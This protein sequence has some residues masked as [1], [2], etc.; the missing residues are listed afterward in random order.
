MKI[1]QSNK[2]FGLFVIVFM[3][4]GIQSNAQEKIAVV[5]LSR[6]ENTE[7]VAKLIQEKVGGNLIALEKQ[8]PYPENYQEIVAQVDRENE[9][10][11]LP[12][13]KTKIENLKDYDILFVGFPTWDMQMPPPM[14][15]FLTENDLSG[16][17]VIPFNTN[18]GFGVGQGFDQLR[19]LC[20]DSKILKGF[21]VE[22]G[23]EKKGV[24]LAIKGERKEKVEDQV[25]TWLTSIGLLEKS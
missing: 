24:L 9:E 22:G 25:I 23:Y 20:P 8:D 13:L 7:A 12:P 3:I 14:K 16:K 17:T 18:A 15:S 11:Y 5:Y 4:I 19:E 10:G 21:S 2:L 6:T 1:V